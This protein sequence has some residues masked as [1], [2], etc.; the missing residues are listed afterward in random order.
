MYICLCSGLK[1]KEI[2]RLIHEENANLQIIIEKTGATTKCG[3]CK[4]SILKIILQEQ[5]VKK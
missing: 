2:K 1:I 4:T 5:Q 3:K